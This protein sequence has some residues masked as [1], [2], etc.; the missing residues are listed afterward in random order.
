[1]FYVL[2][3]SASYPLVNFSFS[4]LERVKNRRYNILILYYFKR[5]EKKMDTVHMAE[6]LRS[7]QAFPIECSVLIIY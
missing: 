5:G 7:V 1:M 2:A 6:V 4:K 3:Q